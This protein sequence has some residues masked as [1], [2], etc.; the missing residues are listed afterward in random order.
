MHKIVFSF[1]LVCLFNMSVAQEQTPN[2]ASSQ[3]GQAIFT[4]GYGAPSIIRAYLKYKTTRDQIT[5]HGSGPFIAKAEY[6]VSNKF[7]IGING[8]YS[9]SRVSWQDFGYDTLQNSY[10][11]FEFGIKAYEISGTFRCNYHFM[12]RKK[13]DMYAGLAMG[14]GLIHMWSYTKAHTTKF[15]IVYDFP[16]PLS[17]ECTWGMRYFPTK[18]FGLYTEA[19]IGKSWILFQKYFLPEA[20]IQGGLVYKL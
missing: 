1:L 12:Q 16:R 3:K 17:L 18:R 6:M 2:K 9:R 7:G 13:I 10:R 5:V 11:L 4:I 20:L 19:G 15:S 8:S 14:Y